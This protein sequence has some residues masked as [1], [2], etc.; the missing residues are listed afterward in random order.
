[1]FRE[2]SFI[3]FTLSHDGTV[4]MIDG[5]LF[6]KLVRHEA[7]KALDDRVVQNILSCRKKLLGSS[8]RV[9]HHLEGYRSIGAGFIVHNSLRHV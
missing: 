6:D 1:M 4:S 9:L 7:H 3:P 8:G 2:I 5:I